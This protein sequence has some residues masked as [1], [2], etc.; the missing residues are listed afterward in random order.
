MNAGKLPEQ[1]EAV[2]EANTSPQQQE[3]EKVE[4]GEGLPALPPKPPVPQ[5]QQQGA[6]SA[7]IGLNTMRQRV[8]NVNQATK[9]Q[10]NIPPGSDLG[11]VGKLGAYQVAHLTPISA[12]THITSAEL[13]VFWFYAVTLFTTLVIMK[14]RN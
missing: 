1:E 4:I 3:G 14:R 6:P 10:V 11:V 5:R 13:F 2:K 7:S 9:P 12:A 8:P